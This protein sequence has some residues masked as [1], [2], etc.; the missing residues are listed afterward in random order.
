MIKYLIERYGPQRGRMDLLGSAHDWQERADVE[1]WISF[2]EGMMVHT[3]AVIYARWFTDEASAS[4]VEAN[5]ARNIRNN[6]NHLEQTLS[7]ESVG[8][9][10]VGARL[11]AAYVMCAFSAEYTFYVGTGISSEGKKSDDWSKT[12]AWLKGLAKLPSYQR[13]LEKGVMHRFT[14]RD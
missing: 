9:Y 5:M 10:L 12:V 14:I 13:L 3:L 11:T 7:K 1:A 8:G 4:K 2:S 6:L